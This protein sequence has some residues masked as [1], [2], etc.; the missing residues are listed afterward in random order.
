MIFNYVR[1]STIDQ[2]TTRQLIDVPCDREYIDKASGMDA[3]RPEL[4]N[5][6]NNLR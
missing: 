6:L 1:V 5:M 4:Q 2:N 3:K